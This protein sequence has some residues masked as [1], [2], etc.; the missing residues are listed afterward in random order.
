MTD[1]ILNADIRKE[2]GI[3]A[4]PLK[5]QEAFIKQI[6]AVVME[7]T[8]QRLRADVTAEQVAALEHYLETEPETD[9]LLAYL[10]EHYPQFA[11]YLAEATAE[12]KSEMSEALQALEE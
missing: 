3:E 7:T 12:L 1:D 4:L 8:M 10:L 2:L 11:T 6:G 9:V 5:E